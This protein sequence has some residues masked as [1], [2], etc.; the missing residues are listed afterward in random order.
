M[1]GWNTGIP[2]APL[3]VPTPG[4]ARFARASVGNRRPSRWKVGTQASLRHRLR[5][6]PQEARA[7]RAPPSEIADRSDGR[8]EE[9]S[10]QPARQAAV[11]DDGR[12]R[13]V[14]G[15]VGREEAHDVTELLWRAPATQW[16]RLQVL[17]ARALGI[18]LGQPGR[19]D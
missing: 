15:T 11:D 3:A 6:R 9:A 5:C 2:K 7:L 14:A 13:D 12:A 18:E 4:G 1:E 19:V 16:N 8:L 17:F 10:E